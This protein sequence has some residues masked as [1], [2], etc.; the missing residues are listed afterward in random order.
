MK[1]VIEVLQDRLKAVELV[2]QE[3]IMRGIFKTFDEYRYACG[4]LRGLALSLDILKDV[5]KHQEESEDE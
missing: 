1:T 4:V 2:H 3:E 5:A